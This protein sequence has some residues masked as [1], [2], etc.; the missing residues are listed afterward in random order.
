MEIHEHVLPVTNLLV[1]DYLGNSLHSSSF[2]HYSP[3]QEQSYIDRLNELKQ[4]RF[5]R[6]ELV[7][8]LLVFN[9][10]YNADEK[11]IHN[12]NKLE[13][14]SSVV[15]VGG[16][17]AGLLTGPLY[18]IHKIITII[19]QAKRL[20]EQ[21]KIPVVPVFWIAGE[22]HDFPEIN[23]TYAEVNGK[24]KKH[25]L[26]QKWPN[27]HSVS[28]VQ[29][30]R[31]ACMEWINELFH[32]Y[33]E[34]SYTKDILREI[35]DCLDSSNTYIDF[36]AQLLFLMFRDTGLVLV[37]SGN[38]QLRSIEVPFFQQMIEKNDTIDLSLRRQQAR[39]IASDFNLMIESEEGSAHIFFH[40]NGERI[41]L[42]RKEIDGKIYFQG[43][44]NECRF[45][46]EEI[47]SVVKTKADCFSNNVVTRPLMQ[48]L[49]FPTLMFVAG[50]GE[51]AYWAELKEVFESLGRK[52]PPV[53]PRLMAT[54][55]TGSVS[56]EIQELKLE[57]Q[58][59][60]TQG[61]VKEKQQFLNSLHNTKIRSEIS[62][63]KVVL[64]DH[65]KALSESASEIHD[66]LVQMVS[67][68]E[69]IIHN[70]LDFI[71]QEFYKQAQ[72]KNEIMIH[73]YDRIQDLIRPENHPQERMLNVFYFI[74]LFGFDLIKQMV[75]ET[76]SSEY[77]HK[78]LHL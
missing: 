6:K 2:F 12:I 5:P 48:E 14:P 41:L 36:F 9:Q 20:E 16:Q 29:L 18:T 4:Y 42:E 27:K 43:K 54:L 75:E 21:H 62:K 68:N 11:T 53:F 45:T 28:D 23:H 63:L 32:F 15:V 61:V 10:K 72:R 39:L 49:M 37:D 56:R 71:E 55:M 52:M 38:K 26:N 73:R 34:T 59:V 7:E 66:S 51:I 60:L 13:D 35:N 50:P 78:V 44:H 47:L 22:D 33:G 31:V 8:H 40:L 17:Q 24:M 1:K 69:L 25:A 57:V 30:D 19:Q 65:Y 70:Q 76:T 58:S 74:N 77:T 64:E 3:Y 46:K 67:K